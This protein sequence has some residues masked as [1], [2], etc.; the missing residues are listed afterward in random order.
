V[1]WRIA[2]ASIGLILDVIEISRGPGHVVDPLIISTVV[3]GNLALFNRD[4][5]LQRRYAA[6]D[7][8]P[9]DEL[10]RPVSIS[11]VAA[12]L[13]LPYETV[14][15]RINQLAGAGALRLTPK[16]AVV[17]TAALS[18]PEY[19]AGA[20]SR[21]ERV[22][23]F[24]FELKDLGVLEALKLRN[25]E[26]A[27]P[28]LDK[29][30]VRLVNRLIGEYMMRLYEVMLRRV[31]DP[32]SGLLALEMGRANAERLDATARRTEAPMPD[33]VRS[34]VSTASL[35]KRL[36]LPPETVRRHLLRLQRLGFCRRA[37]GG[38]LAELAHLDR[39]D[40]VAPI[41]RNLMNVAR[42]VSRLHG[43]GVAAFWEAEA[44]AA[45]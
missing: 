24:Y 21:Y 41:A 25:S 38:W 33:E 39:S 16:G 14:R 30:P 19:L 31:G 5:E 18:T 9:P 3:E 42:L 36:R 11:A 10:R 6:I 12:S 2:R 7:R 22:R 1:T 20:V 35:A 15:R 8:P 43:Y 45:A 37:G 13:H 26:P 17:P 23:Q 27:P 32:V 28:C 34:P 44:R 29:P 40:E 4:P